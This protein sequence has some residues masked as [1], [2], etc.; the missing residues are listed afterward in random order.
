MR[1]IWPGMNG[2][3]DR[4]TM[5]N[6]WRLTPAGTATKLPGDMPANIIFLNDGKH[7]LVNT[8]GFHDHSLN[9]IE[10]ETGKILQT[11]PFKQAWVGLTK[12][13]SGAILVSGAKVEAIGRNEAV[14]KLEFDGSSLKSVPGFNLDGI[15]PKEQFAS[16]ML[17]T[18]EGTYVLNIQS[19]EI[20][21]VKED[22]QVV[23]RGNTGYRPY[24]IALSP[25]GKS[26]AV[27]NWGD[28]SVTILD[29]ATLRT[30]ANVKVQSMPSAILYSPDGRLF[31]AN[32][33]SNSVSVIINNRVAESVR[34]GIDPTDNIGSTP[35][36][37]AIKPD[38]KKIYVANAG[39]N[40]VTVVD[41]AEP[42]GIEIEGYIP[43]GR[44][45]SAIAVTP[46]GKKLLIATAKGFYGPNAGSK[47]DLS[48][49]GVRGKDQKANFR[50][51]GNQLEGAVSILDIPRGDV[52]K[53]MTAQVMENAPLGLKSAP[54]AT[55]V[56]AIHK[57]AFS[58][59]KHVIYVIRE[60]RTFDQV[61]G[62]LGKGNGDS[63]L[64]MF[65]EKVTPNGHK[66]AREF[67]CFDNF[68]TDGETSQVGHQW[69]DAAYAN[70]YTEK[71]MILGYSRRG[72]V[73]A[74]T[75]L[76]S[77]PGEY[78]WSQAKKHG[79]TAR[80]YGEYVDV[81]VDH[82][83]LDNPEMKA[84]PE[85]FGYS[86]SFEKI[87]ASGG[88]DTEK[89]ADFLKEMHAAE[90]N[91]N[92]PNLMV[93]ALPE[94]HTNGLSAGAHTPEAMVGN[95]DLAIGQLIEAVSHSKFWKETAIFIIQDDAQDGP[96]HVDSHRTVAYTV[97]PYIKRGTLDSTMYSTSS[98]LRTMGLILGIPPMTQYDAAA[99]PM[100][101]AFTT[102]ANLAPFTLVK[103]GVDLEGRNPK[104]TAL[105]RRSAKL[106]FSDVDKADWTELN[107]ILWEHTKPGQPYP[108]PV[109]GH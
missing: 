81:Q 89:V 100:Y 1:I 30:K 93:M 60:N 37:M 98:M 6:G 43:T 107:K 79:K 50:Y 104:N 12:T 27:S 65:G 90:K 39:N 19:D 11:V 58:K 10:V 61:L 40:C 67:A 8:C 80:V 52:L 49:A 69:A 88:R 75:R 91:G 23:R 14:H 17:S 44:Y 94:D 20:L 109:R 54:T 86:A 16:N 68:Y 85:K 13:A 46:D 99:T 51:I 7:A 78:L 62:D 35:L 42:E 5:P 22:G 72:E 4:F 26:L 2:T 66:I 95:N 28:K 24:G 64:T 74:D 63:S 38:G 41:I 73:D 9:L 29:P 56:A 101:A 84:N 105:A 97:S 57:E 21:L 53:K 31:V 87:F 102:K 33:G 103:P 76:S 36:A 48:G 45:P 108:A 106:D 59:I 71:Q 83:S 47:V 77:S 34:T 15:A 96:D 70:D 25:D 82:G 55:E 32:S 3:T 92:W 18:P